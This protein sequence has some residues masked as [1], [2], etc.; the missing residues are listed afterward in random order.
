MKKKFLL[1][2]LFFA[3]CMFSACGSATEQ[4]KNE[5]HQK[6]EENQKTEE[7]GKTNTSGD[8]KT[9]E[10]EEKPEATPTAIPEQKKATPADVF[11]W[12]QKGDSVIITGINAD[13][14][15]VLGIEEIVI[16]DEIYGM[17]VEGLKLN[18]LYVFGGDSGFSQCEELK[19]VVI[20][21]GVTYIGEYFFYNC[22]ALKEIVIPESVTRIGRSAFAGTAWA[23][24]Q[25]E[26]SDYNI[27][28]GILIDAR[29]DVETVIIPEGVT[30]IG[31]SA[32]FGCSSLS[33][34]TIPDN[35][36]SIGSYVFS[37]CSSLTSITIPNSVT[38][39][40][41][42]AFSKCD[43]L[44]TIYASADSAAAKWAAKNGYAV[45]EPI[46]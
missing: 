32:F 30:S 34:I 39:I 31:N 16:P 18:D 17:P 41:N 37:D 33:S 45:E 20:Q 36:P 13:I 22:S 8:S 12:K 15:N 7:S 14:I 46:E 43:N 27:V 44:T 24:K 42:S 40:N 1:A 10:G 23:Q 28:N 9:E 29:A 3:F 26:L 38:R 19:S 21:E 6:T 2:I 4:P 35:V 25:L 11:S 5:E